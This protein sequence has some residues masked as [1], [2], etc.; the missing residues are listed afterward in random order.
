MS[1][2]PMRKAEG[3]HILNTC[4]KPVMMHVRSDT[5]YMMGEA[6]SGLSSQR[7]RSSSCCN[8]LQY[9]YQPTHTR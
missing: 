3:P 9:C 5:I 8:H 2:P 7:V 6:S 4:Q 1:I